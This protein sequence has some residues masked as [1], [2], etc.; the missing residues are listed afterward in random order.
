MPLIKRKPVDLVLPPRK[1]DLGSDE[2]AVFYIQQTG[3]IFLDYEEYVQRLSFYQ[4]HIFQCELSGRIHLTFFEALKS[5]RKE[6]AWVHRN[7]PEPL[8]EPILR[9]VQFYVTGRIDE[10][11]DLVFDRFKDRFFVDETVILD[12]HGDK[13]PA[14]VRKVF[15]SRNLIR[16]REEEVAL[17][18]KI[19]QSLQ[20]KIKSEDNGENDSVLS[21]PPEESPSK[22]QRPDVRLEPKDISHR[23]GTDLTRDSDEVMKEDHPIDDYLYNVQLLSADGE[24]DFSMALMERRA[25][26]LTRDRSTFSKTMLRKYLKDCVIR[27]PSIG[28]PW[29][30]KPIL[31][32]KYGIPQQ[33]SEDI[34][35][36]NRLIKEGKLSKRRKYLEEENADGTVNK[37]PRKNKAEAAK[38]EAERKEEEER[39]KA[40]E[41]RKKMIKYP[42]ED[43]LLEP[44]NDEE[45]VKSENGD[46]I[47][48]RNLRPV[49]STSLLPAGKDLFEP[50]M[51]SYVFLQGCAKA[52]LLSPFHLDDLESA[53]KHSSYDPPCHLVGEVHAALLNIIVRD[54]TNQKVPTIKAVAKDASGD[55]ED[56][57][58][59]ENNESEEDEEAEQIADDDEEEDELD[60]LDSKASSAADESEIDSGEEEDEE[61]E[62]GEKKQGEEVYAAGRKLGRGWETKLLRSENFRAGWEYSLCGILA[63]RS[64]PETFPRGLAIL[65]HLTGVGSFSNG[66]VKKEEGKEEKEEPSVPV[67][68]IYQTPVQRYVTL[69]LGDKIVMLEFLCEQAVLTRGI[70]R[71]FDECEAQLTELRKERVELGRARRKLAEDRAAHE[72]STKKESDEEEEGADG[73]EGE[74]GDEEEEEEAEEEDSDESKPQVNGKKGQKLNGANKTSNGK[75]GRKIAKEEEESAG[76]DDELASTGVPNSEDDYDSSGTV[77]PE[78]R[79]Y[80]RNFG[81]RQ[82]AMRIKAIQREAEEADRLAR[83]RQEREEYRIRQLENK[84]IAVERKRMDDEEAR[85]IKREEAI[86]RE[87]RQHSQAPRLHPLGRDRFMDKYWWFDGVGA[88]SL[89]G[90]QGQIQYSTGR[91]FVQGPSEEEWTILIDEFAPGKEILEQRRKEDYS[92]EGILGADQWAVYTESEDIDTLMLWLRSKGTREHALRHQFTRFRNYIQPGMQKR[93]H[94]LTGGWKD[95]VETRRSNRTKDNAST[96]PAYMNY[97]NGFAKGVQ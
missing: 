44:L 19:E 65:S 25:D 76:E 90:P 57:F 82:E 38:E 80:R 53:L 42:I 94:D 66:N 79:K 40:E 33:A 84:Q 37:K 87:F 88:A 13:F 30:V 9:S 34:E 32:E 2:A 26:T 1:D 24:D 96:R 43:L 93:S 78:D 49:P 47:T 62:K 92:E 58:D 46:H 36:K 16:R 18:M 22:D 29:V 8:K 6:S 52:L 54:F 5:E 86:E 27:D 71:F 17:S 11:V 59:E 73:E 63:K 85:I 67:N 83:Q 64:N 48:R 31:A 61:G 68:D 95:N 56:E 45:V 75:K 12:I 15:P 35:E 51:N 10:L 20:N 23:I 28:S 60:E 70:K 72:E 81:S 97:R 14:A 89:V 50:M 3:E 4:Q 74:E 21:D 39:R 69:S 7:F 55:E 77:D 91:L 41:R